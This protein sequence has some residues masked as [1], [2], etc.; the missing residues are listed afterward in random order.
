MCVCVNVV[1]WAERDALEGGVGLA[2]RMHSLVPYRLEGLAGWRQADVAGGARR[3]RRRGGGVDG[4]GTGCPNE[5][6][7]N[8]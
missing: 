8:W 1:V 4:G 5:R 2:G 7:K 6:K 3:S